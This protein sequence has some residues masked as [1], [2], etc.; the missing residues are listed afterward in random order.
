MEFPLTDLLSATE[1]TPWILHHFHPQGLMCPKCGAPVANASVFRTTKNSQLSVYRCRTCHPVSPL[2]PNTIFQ[3]CHLA[4][5]QVGGVLKGEASIQLSAALS[6][7]PQPILNL[8]RDGQ[9]RA[10]FLPSKTSAT[11]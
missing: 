9:D 10:R 1:S 11:R 7:S 6:V 4:P 3:P 8:R 5:P 2:S